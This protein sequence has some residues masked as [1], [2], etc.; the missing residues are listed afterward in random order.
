MQKGSTGI[1]F[2]SV[3]KVC[4]RRR[5]YPLPFDPFADALGKRGKKELHGE[6]LRVES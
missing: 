3:N 1:V 4:G 6:K 5:K 2:E